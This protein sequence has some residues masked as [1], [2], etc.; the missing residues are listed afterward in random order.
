MDTCGVPSH[1]PRFARRAELTVLTSGM[2]LFW[3][4]RVT[5]SSGTCRQLTRPATAERR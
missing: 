3:D 5:A 4:D 2:T 1:V